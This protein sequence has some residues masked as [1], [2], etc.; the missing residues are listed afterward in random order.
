[1]T[2][3]TAIILIIFITICGLV[4]AIYESRS[5][6]NSASITKYLPVQMIVILFIATSVL[7]ITCE[8]HPD[9]KYSNKNIYT[10][11]IAKVPSLIPFSK[12]TFALLA[13]YFTIHR[14]NVINKNEQFQMARD[15]AQD[16]RD[17]QQANRDEKQELKDDR[18][19]IQDR[20]SDELNE[21]SNFYS[22]NEHTKS[23]IKSQPPNID[24][25]I[26]NGDLFFQHLFDIPTSFSYRPNPRLVKMFDDLIDAIDKYDSPTIKMSV[27]PETDSPYS[28]LQAITNLL[29]FST[30]KLKNKTYQTKEFISISIDMNLKINEVINC[31][32]LDKK[33]RHDFTK[34]LHE[35][36]CK[37]TVLR[38][39]KASLNL[40]S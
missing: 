25:P 40:N 3:D 28:D 20:K 19:I 12:F 6:P 21:I 24:I 8:Y 22:L 4:Y 35:T 37:L 30:E 36:S 13:V 11:I 1:M 10:D 31:L 33:S 34:F 38:S 18:Q 2:I 27:D 16:K 14:F 23:I 7:L 5:E 29:S 17:R 9:S 39:Q 32:P 15:K 26:V